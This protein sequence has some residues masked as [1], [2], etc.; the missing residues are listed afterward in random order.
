[1]SEAGTAA[2]AVGGLLGAY[3]Q[4][5]QADASEKAGKMNA[6]QDLQ[7]AQ[8]SRAQGADEQRRLRIQTRKALGS[9]KAGYGASG[10]SM[11]GSAMDVL[12]ES[13]ANAEMDV[14]TV[15]HN[16]EMQARQYENQAKMDLYKGTI[17]AGNSQ[18]GAAAQL[19]KTGS[20]VYSKGSWGSPKKG[21]T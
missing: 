17:G 21:T 4:M 11:E 2:G 6:A 7:N 3:G 9:I 16:S 20:D 8:A 13:S 14:W 10:I 5:Q 19:L 12:M 15:G 1:M 18:M